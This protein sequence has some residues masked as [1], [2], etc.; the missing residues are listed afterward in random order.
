MDLFSTVQCTQYIII[1]LDNAQA[2]PDLLWTKQCQLTYFSLDID[3]DLTNYGATCTEQL[4]PKR[5]HRR[6]TPK[7]SD[8]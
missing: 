2:F 5:L 3:G 4:A 6:E 8:I 7:I 1:K